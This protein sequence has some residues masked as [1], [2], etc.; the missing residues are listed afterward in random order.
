[1]KQPEKDFADKIT[2]TVDA[3]GNPVPTIEFQAVQFDEHQV[4][5]QFGRATVDN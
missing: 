5:A 3:R 2:P 4:L 1:M